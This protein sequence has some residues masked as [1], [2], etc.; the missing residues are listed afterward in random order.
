MTAKLTPFQTQNVEWMIYRE[1]HKAAY[2]G[3]ITR[4]YE[5]AVSLPLLYSGS[6]V[7][8][9]SG[10]YINLFTN[11]VTTDRLQIDKLAQRSYKG[12]ILAD[13]MGLGK[14][15]RYIYINIHTNKVYRYMEN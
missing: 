12:G 5:T 2:Q 4:D 13:E 3:T 1:G 7:S 15:V 9:A 6:H 11:K 14:T 10:N 8:Q